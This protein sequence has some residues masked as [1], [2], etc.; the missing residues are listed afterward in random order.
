LSQGEQGTTVADAGAW[1]VKNY[2][3][4]EAEQGGLLDYAWVMKR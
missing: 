2:A 3:A 4:Q 1:T